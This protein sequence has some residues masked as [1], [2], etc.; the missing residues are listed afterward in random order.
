MLSLG[1]PIFCC[2]VTAGHWSTHF[3]S[4]K[5]ATSSVQCLLG[6]EPKLTKLEYII[7]LPKLKVQQLHFPIFFLKTSPDSTYFLLFL[8]T[9]SRNQ[10]YSFFHH[11]HNKKNL[12]FNLLVPSLF[13]FESTFHLQNLVILLFSFIHTTC[14]LKLTTDVDSGIADIE[15]PQ[16]QL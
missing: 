3:S 5:M 1:L 14:P 13:L 12:T 16:I 4:K 15:V 10:S 9:W 6:F 11:F 8:L 2:H 7:Y